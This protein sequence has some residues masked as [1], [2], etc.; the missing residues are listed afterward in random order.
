[1]DVHDDELS[2]ALARL[3]EQG[4]TVLVAGSVP[5]EHH[6]TMSRRLLGDPA[7]GPRR[8]LLALTDEHAD[9]IASRL[10][11]GTSPTGPNAPEVI[12]ITNEERSA[13][14]VS[15]GSGGALVTPAREVQAEDLEGL[16]TAIY[17]AISA[18]EADAGDLEPSELRM[19]F[20]SL[21]PLL[22][23][24]GDRAMFRLLH[25]LNHTLRKRRAM[26]HF[27]LPIDPDTETARL[28]APLFDVLVELRQTNGRVKQRWE[29]HDEGLKTDW[30][31]L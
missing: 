22:H 5:D 15:G 26:G 10:P 12:R 3:K 6:V 4:S 30:L 29:V 27:H 21:S 31:D 19:A 9:D 16:A 20:D 11:A 1:M 2:A 24:H 18:I 13:S 28:L 8:H 17:D 14:A 7:A 23:L 25:L